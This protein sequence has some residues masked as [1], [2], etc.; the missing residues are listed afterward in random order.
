[1][2][3]NPLLKLHAL[4]Q[5]IWLDY[6]RRQMI[7]HGELQKLIDDDGLAGVTSNPAIF[8]KAIA[9]SRDYDEAIR[10][11]ARAG[12]GVAAIYEALTV[13]DVQRAAD[14]FR[15]LYDREDGKDG[16]V[17]L[18]VNPHLARDT[19]ATINEARHLWQVLARPNVLIKVPATQEG[20]PAIRELTREGL[21]V[22]VTLLFGL[23]RYRKV[24]AA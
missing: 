3:A 1:M 18:E 6:I 23:P 11:L 16:F 5:S 8:Q 20:L 9:G 14:L 17:S 4:G 7:N 19:Q 2:N 12:A 22:N 10:T 24:S 21:N 15:S 13:E